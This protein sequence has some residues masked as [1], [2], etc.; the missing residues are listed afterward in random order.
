MPM[1]NPPHPGSSL[2]DA[3]LEPLGLSVTQA[4]K[5]IGVTRAALSRILG[6]KAGISVE[7]ALRLAKAFGGM[8]ETWLKLQLAYDL[9]QARRSIGK[10]RVRQIHSQP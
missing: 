10:L 7:M 1:K 2:R 3:Y 9:A 4:A 5:A 8:A 6:G